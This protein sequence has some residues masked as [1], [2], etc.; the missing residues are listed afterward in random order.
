M[1]GKLGWEKQKEEETE[2]GKNNR[3]QENSRRMENLGGG[4]RSSEVRG[5]SKKVGAREVSQM[6]KS[7]Q[8][9]A[10]RKNANKEGMML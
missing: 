3:V 7:V 5:R 4:R 10:V 9:E 2:K 1:Q 6:D 8:K